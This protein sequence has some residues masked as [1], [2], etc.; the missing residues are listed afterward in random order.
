MNMHSALDV[1]S[2]KLAGSLRKD[3]RYFSES[4]ESERLFEL[5]AHAVVGTSCY[6]EAGYNQ[7][8]AEVKRI[9]TDPGVMCSQKGTGMRRW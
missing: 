3:L 7:Y 1:C 6:P 9:S 5:A 2:L 8:R 4:C